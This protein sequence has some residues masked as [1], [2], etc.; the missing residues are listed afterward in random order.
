MDGQVTTSRWKEATSGRGEVGKWC[1]YVFIQF[2]CQDD[3]KSIDCGAVR[4]S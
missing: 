2:S 1:D 4:A 3:F